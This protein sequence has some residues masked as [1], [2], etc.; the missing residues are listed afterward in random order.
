LRFPKYTG[1]DVRSPIAAIS[2]RVR[3]LSGPAE[4]S[5]V[6]LDG[7]EPLGRHPATA[8]RVLEEGTNLVESLGAAEGQHQQCVAPLAHA[9]MRRRSRGTSD[10]D[11]TFNL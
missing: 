7:V 5:V 3:A 9:S 11:H 4:V 10:R 2:S 8:D 1:D 6:L